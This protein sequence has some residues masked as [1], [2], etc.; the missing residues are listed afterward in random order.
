MDFKGGQ[1]KRYR[2]LGG[3]E[4]EGSTPEELIEAMRK[5]SFNPGKVRQEFMDETAR[6]CY[7]YSKSIINVDYPEKF[8]EDLIK[9]GF[10][11]PMEEN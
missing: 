2:L 5:I 1:M 7:Q 3:G 10:L 9:N 11:I 4:I 6:A 8:I